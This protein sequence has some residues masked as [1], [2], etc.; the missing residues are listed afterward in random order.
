[1]GA[2]A[3]RSVERVTRLRKIFG[4]GVAPLVIVLFVVADVLLLWGRFGDLN[5]P[6]SIF[7]VLGVAGVVL[8]LTGRPGRGRPR[9]RGAVRGDYA[10]AGVRPV[11][12]PPNVPQR[13]PGARREPGAATAHRVRAPARPLLRAAIPP[14]WPA[15]RRVKAGRSGRRRRPRPGR[16]AE[17]GICETDPDTAAPRVLR[18]VR[19]RAARPAPGDHRAA[20]GQLLRHR[21]LPAALPLLP[22][23]R[24]HDRLPRAGERQP[25]SP[26]CCGPR[27]R[28][29]RWS[30]WSPAASRWPASSVPSGSSPAWPR[31]A[32]RSCWTPPGS[33]TSAA[34]CRPCGAIRCTSGSLWTAPIRPRNDALRPANRRHLPPGSQLR[35]LRRGRDQA[36][37]PG[38]RAVQRADRRHRPQRRSRL[39]AGPA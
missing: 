30:A 13:P 16:L 39:A 33:A 9:D 31:P 17:L 11:R 23:R 4:Y 21:L 38:G 24:P 25:G 6:G 12:A 7:A 27:P 1:M 35:R 37:G 22:R 19:R 36:R 34:W 26:G 29:P 20:G 10:P 3:A 2:S 18:P 8:I 5:P 15:L 32:R 28:P 14:I